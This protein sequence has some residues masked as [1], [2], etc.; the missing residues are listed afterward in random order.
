MIIIIKSFQRKT[1]NL[2]SISTFIKIDKICDYVPVISTITSSVNLFQKYFVIPKIEKN[3]SH[4]YQY[5]KNKSTFRSVC[6]LIPVFGNI[7][8]YI[9]DFLYFKKKQNAL[10]LVQAEGMDLSQLDSWMQDDRDV[11]FAASKY[12]KKDPNYFFSFASDRLRCD[13]ELILEIVKTNL[14]V[15][16]KMDEKLQLDSKFMLTAFQIWKNEHPQLK[17]MTS[18]IAFKFY[19]GIHEQL[20]K[21]KDFILNLIKMNSDLKNFSTKI[22]FILDDELINNSEFML[23]VLKIFPN[24]FLSPST[25]LAS[26]KNFM[27]EAMK[28]TDGNAAGSLGLELSKNKDFMLEVIKIYPKQYHNAGKLLLDKEFMLEVLKFHPNIVE[29]LI[30]K[31]VKGWFNSNKDFMLKVLE[32][33]PEMVKWIDD[34]LVNDPDFVKFKK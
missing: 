30:S 16:S 12:S 17:K 22:S 23:E 1:M 5:L 18:D 4:Y 21:N 19:F 15:L 10:S 34:T 31:K 33:N 29:N 8:I 6:L 32:W 13:Q 20:R 24:T 27:I 14:Y 7:V 9:F 28:L 25:K 3:K 2:S 11:V 26:N